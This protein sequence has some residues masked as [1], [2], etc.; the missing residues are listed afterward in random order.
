MCSRLFE[1]LSISSRGIYCL[2]VHLYH[3]QMNFVFCNAHCIFSDGS[4]DLLSRQS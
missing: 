3:Q 1:I 2:I 4:F